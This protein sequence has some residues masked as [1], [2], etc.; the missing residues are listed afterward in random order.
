MR[1]KDAKP[2]PFCGEEI[3]MLMTDS[4]SSS[5]FFCMCDACG[6]QGSYGHD[7]VGNEYGY[8]KAKQ[9]AIDNWN[10]RGEPWRVTLKGVLWR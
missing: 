7:T 5:H 3:I 9:D 8:Q 4:V 10:K 1:V 2:C 6:A